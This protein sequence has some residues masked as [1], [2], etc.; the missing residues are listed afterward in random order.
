MTTAEAIWA[1]LCVPFAVRALIACSVWARVHGIGFLPANLDPRVEVSDFPSPNRV[2][3]E[4]PVWIGASVIAAPIA[5]VIAPLVGPST[6]PELWT[7]A[8]LV[9]AVPA[10]VWVFIRL[11][12][13]DRLWV[14]LKR[15]RLARS[16]SVPRD[17]Q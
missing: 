2:G 7:I 8:Y 14:D 12:R 6:P 9:V 16:R 13:D 4:W 5:W 11:R 15:E 10:V 17:I 1:A 3:R